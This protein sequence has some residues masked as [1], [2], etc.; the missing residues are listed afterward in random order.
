MNFA[1]TW[2]LDLKYYLFPKVY[3]SLKFSDF[4]WIFLSHPE[5][6]AASS[7]KHYQES[8]V[9]VV[10]T[11]VVGTVS[12]HSCSLDRIDINIAEVPLV[13]YC[14]G[15]LS[16]VVTLTQASLKKIQMFMVLI[17]KSSLFT[18]SRNSVKHCGPSS[19]LCFMSLKRT[20]SQVT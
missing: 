16:Q 15:S 13:F 12:S 6:G 11:S 8:L 7:I 18:I 14:S 2:L 5:D 4:H 3:C 20:V 10:I 17:Q 1:K 19:E 9:G